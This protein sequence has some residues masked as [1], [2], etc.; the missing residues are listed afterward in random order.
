MMGRIIRD[1]IL[2]IAG[3]CAGL[4]GGA[5]AALGGGH[6]WWLI[7]VVG[8]FY[9]CAGVIGIMDSMGASRRR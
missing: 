9:L 3:L 7:F 4:Y 6:G 5:R 2:C 1:A 8:A